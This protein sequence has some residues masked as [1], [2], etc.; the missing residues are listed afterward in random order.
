M[1]DCMEINSHQIDELLNP[2][3]SREEIVKKWK[4]TLQVMNKPTTTK[5]LEWLAQKLRSEYQ[6]PPKA[7]S[8][9]FNRRYVDP[10]SDP[11]FSKTPNIKI[12]FNPISFAGTEKFDYSD[13][14]FVSEIRKRLEY[15]TLPADIDRFTIGPT[16]SDLDSSLKAPRWCHEDYIIP[17]DD[18]TGHHHGM[19]KCQCHQEIP[20]LGFKCEGCQGF[21]GWKSINTD[22]FET[23][24]IRF[25]ILDENIGGW[26]GFYCSRSCLLEFPP[27]EITEMHDI[28]IEAVDSIIEED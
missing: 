9:L 16:N 27:Q 3:I 21:F 25:P 26:G 24:I 20:D 10:L 19:L 4:D 28:I 14:E 11:N 17:D 18:N 15:P 7:I 8:A 1:A 23:E 5:G 2:Y 12:A 6:V 13:E 22:W